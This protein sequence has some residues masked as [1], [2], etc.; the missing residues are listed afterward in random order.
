[1]WTFI[2]AFVLLTGKNLRLL[3]TELPEYPDS[4]VEVQAKTDCVCI[5]VDDDVDY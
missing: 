2:A 4:S 3:L 1:M 5:Y